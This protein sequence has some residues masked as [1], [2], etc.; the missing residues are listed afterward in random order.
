MQRWLV[1]YSAHITSTA[2]PHVKGTA[3]LSIIPS[4]FLLPGCSVLCVCYHALLVVAILKI[5]PILKYVGCRV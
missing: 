4:L 5:S 2:L 3:V 1:V